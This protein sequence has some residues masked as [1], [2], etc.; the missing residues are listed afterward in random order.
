MHGLF[1]I[2]ERVAAR[3]LAKDGRVD[4]KLVAR[5]PA[6]D[7]REVFFSKGALLHFHVQHAR[8]GVR[9][10]H[11]REAAGFAIEAVD[12][13]DLSAIRELEGEQFAQS[14][15]ERCAAIWL[16]RMRLDEWRLIDDDPFVGLVDDADGAG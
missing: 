11:E 10:G 15:P 6:P 13:R 12:Q 16:A 3:A 14:V 2:D 7:D 5:W 9:L 4:F 8:G 1:Q